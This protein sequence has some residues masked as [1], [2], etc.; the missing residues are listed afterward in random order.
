[1]RGISRQHHG[2]SASRPERDIRTAL[3]RQRRRKRQ[4]A[5]MATVQKQWK[6]EPPRLEVYCRRRAI[7]RAAAFGAMRPTTAHDNIFASTRFCIRAQCSTIQ[8]TSWP[9]RSDN[10]REASHSCIMGVD[11]IFPSMRSPAGL[12]ASDSGCTLSSRSPRTG[13]T[14]P[15][16]RCFPH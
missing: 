14:S 15:F 4:P 12:C 9:Y 6:L 1:M 3:A 11:S 13:T 7:R 16:N 5:R 8:R 10:G 2:H